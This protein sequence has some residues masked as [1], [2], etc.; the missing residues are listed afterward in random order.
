[1]L[2]SGPLAW[3][4]VNGQPAALQAQIAKLWPQDPDEGKRLVWQWLKKLKAA[5]AAMKG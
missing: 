3:N 4:A 1:M 5:R 2:A